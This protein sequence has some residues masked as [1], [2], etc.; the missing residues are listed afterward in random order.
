LQ[1]F[2]SQR[3]KRIDF[4]E[5]HFVPVERIFRRC[6]YLCKQ[7]RDLPQTLQGQ[8][9]TLYLISSN[10]RMLTQLWVRWLRC[11]GVGALM[12]AFG[13]MGKRRFFSVLCDKWRVWLDQIRFIYGLI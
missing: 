10:V 2:V 3:M 6:R 13:N 5:L 8:T 7:E 9:T 4:V 11:K 12:D 1:N